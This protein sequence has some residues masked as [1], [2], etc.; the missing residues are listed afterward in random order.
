[1]YSSEEVLLHQLLSH[2]KRDSPPH[3]I[4]SS[5]RKRRRKV[6]E[7][8]MTFYEEVIL[9]HKTYEEAENA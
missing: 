9:L 2:L 5:E 6:N 1:M 4:I 7:R 3:I 8:T